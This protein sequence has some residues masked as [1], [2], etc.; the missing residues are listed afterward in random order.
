MTD[1]PVLETKNLTKRFEKKLDSAGKLVKLLGAKIK[2]ETVHAVTD[3]S[4]SIEPGQVIGLVGES[5]CGKSTLGR[6]IANILQ[7]SSG[8]IIY[9]GVKV[10]EMSPKEYSTYRL[11]VQMIFQDPLASL[12][13][14]KQIKSIIGEAPLFHGIVKKNELED[15]LD[16]VMLKSGL[17]PQ[18]KTRY[19]HQ[20]SGGQRQR[21]GIARSLAVNPKLLV[22][23]EAVAS[24]DV[25][26]Q[27]QILNL[28]MDLRE[29][30]N[31][32]YIFISHDLGVVDHISDKI[33]VMY[34]GWIVEMSDADDIFD[35]PKHPYTKALLAE[36]PSL[37]KRH[38]DFA[39]LKG[40]IPSPLDPP[41]GCPFHPRCREIMD[42]CSVQMPEKRGIGPGHYCAC[43]LY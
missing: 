9:K 33:A 12:N 13:P 5:G 19:P 8:D 28:F 2:D 18:L 32:N 6:M 10:S 24:L 35:N 14:R 26:I 1:K 3:I 41:S 15:H 39:P 38:F 25:S 22:C 29:D 37:N 30:L 11:D 20:F 23:D 34:L 40:E 27:A 21:I 17:D 31:L 16:E 42:V 36:I 43:H 7:P 4:I